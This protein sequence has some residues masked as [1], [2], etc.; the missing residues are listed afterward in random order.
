M[1]TLTS[2]HVFNTG[3]W[4]WFTVPFLLFNPWT[5]VPYLTC[6]LERFS[7]AAVLHAIDCKMGST[8]PLF[9]YVYLEI[10][11]LNRTLSHFAQQQASISVCICGYC[12]DYAFRTLRDMRTPIC[13]FDH[14]AISILSGL[15]G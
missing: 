12:L 9:C 7:P 15:D 1:H 11:L 6:G 4:A 10:L 3:I 8:P 13:G 2:M 5:I 14:A